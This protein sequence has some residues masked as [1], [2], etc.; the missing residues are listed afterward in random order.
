MMPLQQTEPG[1]TNAS[2]HCTEISHLLQKHQWVKKVTLDGG[3]K[4]QHVGSTY[5]GTRYQMPKGG[6]ML[7]A[8][9]FY[10]IIFSV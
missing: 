6:L 1:R 10:A 4:S 5:G 8:G 9:L 3:N 2:S 7:F